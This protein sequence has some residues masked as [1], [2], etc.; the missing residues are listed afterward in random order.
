MAPVQHAASGDYTAHRSIKPDLLSGL[1]IATVINPHTGLGLYAINMSHNT[2]LVLDAT[3]NG[4]PLG[5]FSLQLV[6][7]LNIFGSSY[8]CNMT[9]Y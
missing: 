5:A 1:P 3:A 7:C 8:T 6:V 9:A 4:P 2:T